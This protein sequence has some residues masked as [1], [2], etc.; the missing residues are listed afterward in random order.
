MTSSQYEADVEADENSDLGKRRTFMKI[1][2][3]IL[4]SFSS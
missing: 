2:T 3:S 1:F 4:I